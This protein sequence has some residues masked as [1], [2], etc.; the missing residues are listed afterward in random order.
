MKYYAIIKLLKN[1][2]V[3]ID[4]IFFNEEEAQNYI[5]QQKYPSHYKLLIKELKAELKWSL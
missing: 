5:N 4:K 1:N 2:K 3:S